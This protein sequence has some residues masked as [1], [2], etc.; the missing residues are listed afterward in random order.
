MI[1]GVCVFPQ[2][3]YVGMYQKDE[4]CPQCK[5]LLPKSKQWFGDGEIDVDLMIRSGVI[6][7]EKLIKMYIKEN[8][9]TT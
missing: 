6:S 2:D 5:T 4:E 3:D 7:K 8:F 1:C 9:A